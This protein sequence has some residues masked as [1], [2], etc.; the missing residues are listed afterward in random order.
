MLR[1]KI[2]IMDALR[3]AGVSTYQLRKGKLLSET[4]IQRLRESKIVSIESIDTICGLLN[5]Q[6]GDLIEFTRDG[7]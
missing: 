3:Q 7:N 6:P 5:K 2:N 1:Y 4:T